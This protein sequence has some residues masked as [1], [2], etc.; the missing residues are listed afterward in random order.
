MADCLPDIKMNLD[1]RWGMSVQIVAIK[2]SRTPVYTAQVIL[3]PGHLG[4]ANIKTLPSEI[5]PDSLRQE[6]NPKQ[7]WRSNP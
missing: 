5:K 1:A 2:R 7:Q 3:S 6:S 4:A